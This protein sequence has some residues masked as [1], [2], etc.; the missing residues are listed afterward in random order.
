MALFSQT[1]VGGIQILSAGGATWQIAP[2]LGDLAHVDAG[3]TTP[4]GMF[5]SKWSLAGNTLR[6]KISA[7]QGTVGTVGLPLPNNSTKAT[8]TGGSMRGEEVEG[9]AS[10]RFWINDLP[11]GDY[12][13]VLTGL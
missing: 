7:P 4:K 8:L 5:S 13:F 9:D 3:L 2:Q 10:G 1:Y 11:G 6:L 12:Q